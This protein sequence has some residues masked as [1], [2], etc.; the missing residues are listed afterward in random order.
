MSPRRQLLR[1]GLALLVL[2]GPLGA[3]WALLDGLPAYGEGDE[4]TSA[5]ELFHSRSFCCCTWKHT[6]GF[7]RRISTFLPSVVCP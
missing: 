3:T 5:G 1:A 6:K 2:L 7:L 4:S